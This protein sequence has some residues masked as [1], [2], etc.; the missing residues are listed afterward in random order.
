L[1]HLHVPAV[2]Q[3]FEPATAETR[4]E[5][6]SLPDA[7][8]RRGY[9]ECNPYDFVG[10]G[11]YAPYRRL[12]I[13][14]IAIP[15]K[16]GHT[17]DFGYDVVVHFHGQTALR[18]TL[19]QVAKGVTFV[20]VDLGNGSGPYSDAFL[21]AQA[22]PTMRD[23]IEDALRAQSGDARAHIRHLGLMAWSAGYGAVNEILKHHSDEVDA[24]VL[25]DGLHAAWDVRQAPALL[26]GVEPLSFNLNA[27]NRAA[28]VKVVAGPVAPTV[29]FARLAAAGEKL[30][31]FTHSEVDPMLYPS[32]GDTA[33]FL[34]DDLGLTAVPEVADADPYGLKAA[35]DVLG[36]HLWSYRGR[37]KAAH[38]THLSHVDRAVRDILEPTW[39][40]PAMDRDVPPTPAPQLGGASSPVNEPLGAEAGQ[41]RVTHASSKLPT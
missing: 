18:M 7:L 25:L 22:W 17:A 14:R 3:L 21:S 37:D 33:R 16:G 27:A 38:C 2:R 36:F 29:E 11:P 34:V 10:L 1:G 26:P 23:A 30:F 6:K 35:V 41:A 28:G 40:T 15:Q 8:R 39:D 24:V 31:I 19:A 12:P 4:L 13:G 20:G 5:A 9:S 32:T